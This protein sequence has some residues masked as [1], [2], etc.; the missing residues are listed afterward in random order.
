MMIYE[1]QKLEN[2]PFNQAHV[3]KMLKHLEIS[4]ENETNLVIT[5]DNQVK[6]YIIYLKN[7]L[8]VFYKMGNS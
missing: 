4:L 1:T 6:D 7:D 8:F 5:L 3:D 2:R